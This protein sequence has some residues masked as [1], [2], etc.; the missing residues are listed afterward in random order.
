[1]KNT[2][3]LYLELGLC[4]RIR[5]RRC[6]LPHRCPL[7][8]RCRYGAWVWVW[9]HVWG[10]EEEDEVCNEASLQGSRLIFCYR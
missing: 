8:H 5:S 10:E 1:M 4:R 7:P 9:V 2:D 3:Y 6:S